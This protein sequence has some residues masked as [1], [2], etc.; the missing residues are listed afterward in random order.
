[1][2][3]TNTPLPRGSLEE[4]VYEAIR[5]EI[6]SG[7]LVPGDPLV[8]AQLSERFGTSKSPVREALIRLKRDGLADGTLHRTT[9]VATPTAADIHQACEVRIWIEAQLA[10]N[11]AADPTDRLLRRL[12]LSIRNAERALDRDDERAYVK[13][14]RS[15]SDEL[16]K[17]SDNRYAVQFLARLRDRLALIANASR[18]VAGRRKRSIEEHKAILDA[19][20]RGD[21]EAAAAAT[22]THLKS[23]EADSLAAV[24][25]L[26]GGS[27]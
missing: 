11:A 4:A 6:L 13:A 12:E 8:E 24:E 14:V 23:I 2:N 18:G 16:I 19:I 26:A 10:A 15:F 21:P 22:R 9:R 17:E 25:Q 27:E 3:R 1:M 7:Q 5:N 20:R